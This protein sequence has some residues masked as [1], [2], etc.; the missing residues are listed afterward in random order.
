MGFGR[1]PAQI[2]FLAGNLREAFLGRDDNQFRHSRA[3]TAALQASAAGSPQDTFTSERWELLNAV[4]E[5]LEG[6]PEDSPPLDR[7]ALSQFAS[8]L[9]LLE[10]LQDPAQTGARR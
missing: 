1:L 5:A 2:S 10:S 6:T 7:V 3:A 8:H 9:S 4:S